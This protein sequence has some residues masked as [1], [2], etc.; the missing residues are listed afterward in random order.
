MLVVGNWG[1]QR[2]RM[3]WLEDE[4]AHATMLL[5]SRTHP[6]Y[7]SQ[8]PKAVCSGCSVGAL[9]VWRGVG[10]LSDAEIAFPGARRP[11]AR[12][13]RQSSAI[14]RCEGKWYPISAGMFLID[15]K[16]SPTFRGVSSRERVHQETIGSLGGQPEKMAK[17]E[18]MKYQ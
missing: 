7:R 8:R 18:I 3:L 1:D 9:E 15:W 11:D 5:P 6:G 14:R 10:K 2:T 16:F 4:S 13:D 12:R 17:V